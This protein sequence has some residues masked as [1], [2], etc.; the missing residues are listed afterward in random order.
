MRVDII[1]VKHR[2]D[3]KR[4]VR[5]PYHLYKK[6]PYWIPPLIKD[7]MD[8]LTAEKNPA[9]AY[10]DVALWLAVRRGK[11]VGRIAGIINRKFIE[12]WKKE[13]AAFGWYD[14]IDDPDVSRRLFETAEDWARSRG[15]K[16][17]H[18]PMG[19]TNFDHQGMLVEGFEYRL[20]E[21]ALQ[22]VRRLTVPMHLDPDAR[23]GG[24]PALEL[25][26]TSVRI[27]R[28][29]G[30]VGQNPIGVPRRKLEDQIVG[31]AVV[32]GVARVRR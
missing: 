24:N 1:E 8:T 2:R 15:M 4:F 18:G 17:I 14:V 28:R 32:T 13:Q 27:G 12:T 10:C 16:E 11:V 30:A 5:F 6:H 25:T 21:G 31:A 20:H 3:L 19:L 23:P 9:F 22:A 29:Q 7:E 26:S